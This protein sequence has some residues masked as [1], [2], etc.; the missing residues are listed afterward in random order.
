[1]GFSV[2]ENVVSVKTDLCLNDAVGDH[3]YRHVPLSPV[4][5]TQAFGS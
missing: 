2:G 5:N 4:L 1:M 3:A